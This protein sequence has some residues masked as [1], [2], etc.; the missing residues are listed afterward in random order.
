MIR[1]MIF[2][3]SATLH[4]GSPAKVLDEIEK[5]QHYPRS[6]F[7]DEEPQRRI[8]VSAFYIDHF[9]VT[10]S[11][12]VRFTDSTSY[13][14]VAERRGFGLVYG[15]TSWEEIEGACWYAPGGVGT[16]IFNRLDHPVVHI[17]YAD[18]VAYAGWAGKR[19]P[20]EEEWEY[21]ARGRD[22]RWWPWGNEWD[23][24]KAITAEY[25]SRREIASFASWRNWWAEYRQ[26][27]NS[28]PG[29]A[30]V[31][32]LGEGATSPFGVHDMA[33]NV[34]EWTSSKYSLPAH[35]RR[36][37]DMYR[38]IEGRYMVLRGGSW[39]NFRYQVRCAERIPTDGT[40]YSTF[41]V[42]FRCARDS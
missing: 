27:Y 31:G 32:S 8:H 34:L 16:G 25:W 20:S 24:Q 35:D 6:W 19:L 7:E 9:L 2:I 22:F 39:M 15:D 10:N 13:R 28:I 40:G 18:A 11:D 37:D 36:Y 21:A 14:T 38:L 41:A 42:G 29:T 3:P 30:A 4:I 5:K 17:A 23:Q 33:G 26:H 12:F 1:N